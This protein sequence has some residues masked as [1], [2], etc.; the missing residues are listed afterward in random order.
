WPPTWDATS[1]KAGWVSSARC[2]R[3]HPRTPGFARRTAH[4]CR[5]CFRRYRPAASRLAQP[6]SARPD[7]GAVDP[8]DLLAT[9]DSGKWRSDHGSPPDDLR[10]H[11]GRLVA[12]PRAHRPDAGPTPHDLAGGHGTV[13]ALGR[14]RLERGHQWSLPHRRLS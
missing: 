1:W 4:D 13:H 11:H 2:S 10:A 5:R 14:Y 8:V 12:G 6:A 9:D 3:P 7:H